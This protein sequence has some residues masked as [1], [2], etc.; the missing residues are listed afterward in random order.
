MTSLTLGNV[1]GPLSLY[2]TS[3][4]RKLGEGLGTRLELWSFERDAVIKIEII[5]FLFY[6]VYSSASVIII[7]VA[8]FDCVVFL[9][10]T[11]IYAT[12]R[13]KPGCMFTNIRRAARIS[14]SMY[15]GIRV[16]DIVRDL[17]RTTAL[18]RL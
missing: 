12:V 15:L 1:P 10:G 6:A 8:Y 5:L 9:P 18:Y 13:D 4:H 14:C 3:S 7:S 16:N 2:R 17:V 11:T